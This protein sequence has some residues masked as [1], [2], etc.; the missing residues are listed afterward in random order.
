MSQERKDFCACET[1]IHELE[2]ACQAG[3][4]ATGK[5]DFCKAY[6]AYP[7]CHDAVPKKEGV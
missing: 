5:C 2:V 6:G 1:C 7:P 3:C 4:Q